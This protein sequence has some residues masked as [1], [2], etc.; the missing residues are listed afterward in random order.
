MNDLKQEQ[1]K[2]FLTN[3]IQEGIVNV[4]V[5][6]ELPVAQPSAVPPATP[7]P[8]PE[9]NQSELTTQPPPEEEMRMTVESMVDKLNVLRG[10][11][12][13]TDPEVFGRLTTFFNGLTDEQ[14]TSFDYL[15]TELGKVVIGASEEEAGLEDQQQQAQQPTSRV[16]Q[17]PP[18]PASTPAASAAPVAPTF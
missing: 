7:P 3:L 4:L 13:F 9:T 8:A 1:R 17:P 10:G 16:Q 12:S 11:R 15:L 18:A 5:E 14:K 6:Q 2:R